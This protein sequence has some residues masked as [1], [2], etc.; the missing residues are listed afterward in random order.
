MLEAFTHQLNADA[1]APSAI[2]RLLRR[3]LIQARW[4]TEDADDLVLAVSEAVS[5]CVEHGYRDASTVGTVEVTGEEELLSVRQR[6]VVITIADHGRW[7]PIPTEPANR[8]RGIPFM[9]ALADSVEID[10][11]PTGTRLTLT[12]RPVSAERSEAR[13]NADLGARVQR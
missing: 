10:G 5:N 9:H 6:R 11:T 8:R 12:S 2:R 4:P 13:G 7:R 3:W 1:T